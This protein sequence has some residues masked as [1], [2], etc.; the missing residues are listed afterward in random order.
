MRLRFVICCILSAFGV[1]LAAAGLAISIF[2]L[3]CG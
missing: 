3:S 1:G 2:S